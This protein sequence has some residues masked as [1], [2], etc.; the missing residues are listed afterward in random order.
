MAV[1]ACLGETDEI[2]DIALWEGP[3]SPG[4]AVDNPLPPIGK[5]SIT[6]VVNTRGQNPH[7]GLGSTRL[8]LVYDLSRIIA[9]AIVKAI[10]QVNV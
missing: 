1:D 7:L 4:T 2:G 10:A 8:S 9:K 5:I 3:V 6:A